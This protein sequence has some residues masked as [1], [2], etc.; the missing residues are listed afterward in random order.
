MSALGDLHAMA[1]TLWAEARGE[2]VNGMAEVAGVIIVRF[3]NPGWWTRDRG[4]DIPD[5]TI[6]AACR[7]PWQFSCWNK[8]D[9]NLPKMLAMGINHPELVNA[10][11]VAQDVLAGHRVPHSL[12]E[13]CDHYH[14]LGWSP[15]WLNIRDKD[16]NIVGR[17]VPVFI[18]GRHAF[19]KI[20][21]HG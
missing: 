21:L 2:G 10:K 12:V 11:R 7:D 18:E 15:D 20:G 16:K 5:D 6:E 14:A 1:L 4:D 17:R 19:Y 13:G 3:N 8:N 9:P